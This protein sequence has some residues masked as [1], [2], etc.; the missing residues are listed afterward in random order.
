MKVPL[1]MKRPQGLG[2]GVMAAAGGHLRKRSLGTT[3][4]YLQLHQ[5]AT[6]KMYKPV[7]V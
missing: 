5:H 4:L 6:G 7:P 1:K 2:G 3:V